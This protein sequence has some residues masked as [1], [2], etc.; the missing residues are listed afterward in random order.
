[1]LTIK[2]YANRK[3][4]NTETKQ[5][6]TLQ[7]I[8]DLVRTG[9]E[10]VF[11]VD[12]KTGE[13]LTAVTF[14]QILIEQERLKNGSIPIGV[15]ARLI[16]LGSSSD[17]SLVDNIVTSVSGVENEIERRIRVLTER[18]EINEESADMLKKK[19]LSFP[20]AVEDT[21]EKEPS[22]SDIQRLNKNI[23]SLLAKLDN[24]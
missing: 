14:S 22:Q 17:D 7:G 15:L 21:N 2:R 3:L 8:A 10:K 12:N 18:G 24:A 1:M 13:D 20:N 19:L 4:Y 9:G 6:I 23:E 11:V 16:K 5:Y